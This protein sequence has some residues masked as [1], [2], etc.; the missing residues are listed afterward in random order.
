MQDERAAFA[1]LQRKY[2]DSEK[3]NLQL[4]AQLQ[5]AE[6]AADQPEVRLVLWEP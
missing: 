4:L 5:N 3:R 6:A 1:E 2:E